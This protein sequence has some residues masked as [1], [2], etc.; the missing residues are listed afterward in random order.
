FKRGGATVEKDG[1]AIADTLRRGLGDDPLL[2]QLLS[3]AIIQRWEVAVIRDEHGT[4]VRPLDRPV[5][6]PVIEVAPDGGFGRLQLLGQVGEGD[7]ASLAYQV[8]HFLT[9][10]FHN[11]ALIL[12]IIIA[13]SDISYPY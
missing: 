2:L 8:Q 6:V 3:R 10:L 5:L 4:A 13:D 11:H 1:V 9:A 7:K 12:S